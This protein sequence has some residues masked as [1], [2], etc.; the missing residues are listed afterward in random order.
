MEIRSV[1][2]RNQSWGEACDYKDIAH[3][4]YEKQYE[5]ES[6]CICIYVCIYD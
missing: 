5:K 3:I 1:V 2:A 4:L 6:V